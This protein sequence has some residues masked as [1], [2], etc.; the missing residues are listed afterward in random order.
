MTDQVEVQENEV[1]YTN[2]NF[3]RV[4]INKETGKTLF[5]SRQIRKAESLYKPLTECTGEDFN[6]VVSDGLH[7]TTLTSED[8][9][10]DYEVV[11]NE[12]LMRGNLNT[13]LNF[14]ASNLEETTEHIILELN[15]FNENGI[16]PFS[17]Y[18]NNS[19]KDGITTLNEGIG[20]WEEVR[21]LNIEPGKVQ[22][23]LVGTFMLDRL[24][25]VG[26]KDVNTLSEK[27]NLA[28]HLIDPIAIEL[29]DGFQQ[30][31]AMELNFI[32][33]VNLAPAEEVEV[34]TGETQ[35]D[36]PDYLDK[37]ASL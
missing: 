33:E 11:P 14:Q 4:L 8:I 19:I 37:L 36:D 31:P 3:R 25:S 24:E 26:C 16:T 5:S 17:V 18:E 32:E 12:R 1:N 23:S 35:P 9:E 15:K 27:Y 30:L 7:V 13:T 22:I 21:L 10:A 2:T 34:E 6:L 29:A 28:M 20:F